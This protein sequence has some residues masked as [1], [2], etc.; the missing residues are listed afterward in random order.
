MSRRRVSIEVIDEPT[1]RASDSADGDNAS[2]SV[3]KTAVSIF[4]S[5][6]PNLLVSQ[7]LKESWNANRRMRCTSQWC[8]AAFIDISGFSSLASELQSMDK[9]KGMGKTHISGAES[10]TIFLNNTLQRLIDVVADFEGDIVKF[11]GDAMIVLWK[12][13]IIKGE[14]NSIS[15]E[16]KKA[17]AVAAACT[18]AT[19]AIET[20]E[21][22]GVIGEN[23][24]DVGTSPMM[25]RSSLKK[26][27]KLSVHTGIGCGN[28]TA[29]HVGGL[30]KRWE[31]FVMGSA[32]NEMNFAESL[33]NKGETVI[34]KGSIELL[35][36]HS[37]DLGISELKF[38][39]KKNG[40][41]LLSTFK[42]MSTSKASKDK[43]MRLS[44]DI[45]TKL[46]NSLRSY[47]PAPIVSAVDEGENLSGDGVL[48]ELCVLFIK[49][50]SLKTDF[51]PLVGLE[52][53]AEHFQKSVVAIQEVSE[54]V[55]K[56]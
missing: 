54:R 45:V 35:K 41:A 18:C 19:N 21:V 33:A 4:L 32:C 22:L 42:C 43:I 11:A 31:F 7:L 40:Y 17:Q 6:V 24:A 15:T 16:K 13:D 20:L 37:Q 39:R 44:R 36:A 25:T 27:A 46:D 3:Q 51:D 48:R 12:V 14:E 55:S 52:R 9:N 47:I 29:F 2:L 34:S 56:L 5:F 1:E 23:N 28:V 10:L 30:R 53:T 49:L 8:A 26:Q 38:G 50:T